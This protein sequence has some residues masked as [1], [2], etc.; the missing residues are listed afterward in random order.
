MLS[1]KT[2]TA[3]FYRHAWLWFMVAMAVIIAGFFKSFFSKM[4]ETDLLH[5]FH[6]MISSGWIFLLI[7][8][9]FLYSRDKI[10]A[11]RRLGKISFL[12]APL[13][14]VSGLMMTHL[15][16]SR[17]DGL[18][19]FT[20]M[21]SFLDVIFLTQFIFFYVSAI[22]HR[23]NMQLHARYMAGTV[24]ALLPPGLGRA[25]ALIP[26]LTEGTL[27][28]DVTYI[29]LE[30]TSIIL[31][32]DDKRK[33]KIYPPYVITFLFFVFQHISLH[34]VAGWPLWQ[35]LMNAFARL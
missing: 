1:A 23:H 32:M 29:L 27:G 28:L 5:H 13:L 18:N 9:P 31:I 21:I 16:L 20:Y 26:A 15:M 30:L 35:K 17:K 3:P 19:P 34:F 12:L 8:Q 14:V 10:G 11:H 6:G 2:T 7:I 25:T 33:G 24:L 4:A 22:K